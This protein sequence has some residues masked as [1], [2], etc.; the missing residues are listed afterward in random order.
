MKTPKGWK[1]LKESRNEIAFQL[2]GKNLRVY[3]IDNP[4]AGLDFVYYENKEEFIENFE[5]KSSA[6]DFAHQWMKKHPRG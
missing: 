5:K 3:V 4:L 6:L 1:K 2:V